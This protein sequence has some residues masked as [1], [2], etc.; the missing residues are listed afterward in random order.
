VSGAF[1]RVLV[2]SQFIKELLSIVHIQI[3]YNKLRKL[4]K[5]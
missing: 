5:A 1:F 2:M 3:M 4:K